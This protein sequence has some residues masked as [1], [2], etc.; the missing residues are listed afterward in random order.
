[1]LP[2]TIKR[3]DAYA[4]HKLANIHIPALVEIIGEYAFTTCRAFP[5][6]ALRGGIEYIETQAFAQCKLLTTVTLP[7]TL[8]RIGPGAFPAA[9]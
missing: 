1:M 3:I 2:T 8:K 5:A 6:L 7:Q 4:F 9:F